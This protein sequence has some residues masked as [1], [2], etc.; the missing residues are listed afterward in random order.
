MSI[1]QRKIR[2]WKYRAVFV[3]EFCESWKKWHNTCFPE[4]FLPDV[5]MPLI[6][7]FSQLLLI[8]SLLET[9]LW[10]QVDASTGWN[11]PRIPLMPS[12]RWSRT[13]CT[14]TRTTTLLFYVKTEG[15]QEQSLG[16]VL[17]RGWRQRD[18]HSV[19]GLVL[20]LRLGFTLLTL[21]ELVEYLPCFTHKGNTQI[22]NC[23]NYLNEYFIN[24][25]K[26]WV[27]DTMIMPFI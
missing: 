16:M 17:C 2:L 13:L 11:N 4:C 9:R 7:W 6:T 24:K 12:R 26:N 5:F 25:I 14:Y 27:L 18:L 21:V 10:Y 3:P 22:C 15:W 20:T 8:V 23:T 1:K 19:L